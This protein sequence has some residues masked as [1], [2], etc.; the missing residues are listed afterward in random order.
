MSNLIHD[1]KQN[2]EEASVLKSSQG[3]VQVWMLDTTTPQNKPVLGVQVL[4]QELALKQYQATFKQE[5]A[6]AD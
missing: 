3:Q 2:A 6:I 1:S 4:I 5:A